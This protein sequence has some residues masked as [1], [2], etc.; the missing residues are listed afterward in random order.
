MR[1]PNAISN[2]RRRLDKL[3]IVHADFE[4]I[5]L[6]SIWRSPVISREVTLLDTSALFNVLLKVPCDEL[7]TELIAALYSN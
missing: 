6:F 1:H 7:D 4:R 3:A 5:W 2:N